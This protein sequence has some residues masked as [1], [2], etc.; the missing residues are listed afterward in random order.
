MAKGVHGFR[1]IPVVLEAV[2]HRGQRIKSRIQRTI[3]SPLRRHGDALHRGT[4]Y[5]RQLE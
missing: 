1:H 5:A 3:V 4:R 2:K